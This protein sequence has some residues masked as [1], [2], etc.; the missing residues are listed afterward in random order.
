MTERRVTMSKN[1]T[2]A[3]Q[4]AVNWLCEAYEALFMVQHQLS[5]DEARLLLDIAEGIELLEEKL[6]A[7]GEEKDRQKAL[8]FFERGGRRGL[9]RVAGDETLDRLLIRRTEEKSV[10]EPT[11]EEVRHSFVRETTGN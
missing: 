5:D 11:M 9:R 2:E 6:N 10:K 1:V 3:R 7:K 8:V 4:G